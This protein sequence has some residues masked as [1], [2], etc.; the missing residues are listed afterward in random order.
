LPLADKVDLAE[1]SHVDKL[2]TE[3]RA[4]ILRGLFDFQAAHHFEADYVNNPVFDFDEFRKYS[5]NLQNLHKAYPGLKA[6]LIAHLF[7]Q[8]GEASRVKFQTSS[9]WAL[10]FFVGEALLLGVQ[11]SDLV[12]SAEHDGGIVWSSLK[13][14]RTNMWKLWSW[15]ESWIALDVWNVGEYSER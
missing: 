12:R 7:A 5:Q 10:R 3:I 4:Q 2:P 11:R 13:A 1:A 14:D 15:E 9:N 8:A 6:D